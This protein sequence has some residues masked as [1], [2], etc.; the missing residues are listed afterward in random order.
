MLVKRVIMSVSFQK[1]DV[2]DY[3]NS[4]FLLLDYPSNRSGENRCNFLDLQKYITFN[5]V[6]VTVD[7]LMSN[8]FRENPLS[9]F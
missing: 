2:I 4:Y 5:G 3:Y 6:F 9:G 1:G 8:I 7:K